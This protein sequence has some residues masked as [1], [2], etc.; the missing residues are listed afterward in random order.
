MAFRLCLPW[1][2]IRRNNEAL[3][4]L[5]R[6]LRLLTIHHHHRL[7]ALF[8]TLEPVLIRQVGGTHLLFQ[9]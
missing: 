4:C 5:L 7:G 9:L 2:V 3:P 8:G 1:L 6:A